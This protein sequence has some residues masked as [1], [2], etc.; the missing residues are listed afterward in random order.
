MVSEKYQY[1]PLTS[2]GIK[3]FQKVIGTFLFY[4][5]A[6]DSTLLVPLGASGASKYK[7]TQETMRLVK[8][9]ID[10]C[11]TYPNVKLCLSARDAVL[12]INSDAS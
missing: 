8:Q 5:C 2:N 12:K 11:A 3:L 6:V 4:V 10:Y 9:V 7:G 1:Q